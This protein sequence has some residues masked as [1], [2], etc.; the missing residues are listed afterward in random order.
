MF[1]SLQTVQAFYWLQAYYYKFW[2]AKPKSYES[3]NA[4]GVWY[5]AYS[6]WAL[7]ETISVITMVIVNVINVLLWCLTATNIQ[8]LIL[9]YLNFNSLVH[10]IDGLRFLWL[11]IVRTIGLWTDHYTS[12]YSYKKQYHTFKVSKE[13][14]IDFWDFMMEFAAITI[15]FG[16]YPD[17][18]S[19]KYIKPK[20]SGK[21]KYP[22]R[23]ADARKA[24]ATAVDMEEGEDEETLEI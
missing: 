23:P 7:A 18:K 22:A 14:F 24:A 12:Y 1:G 13:H 19:I 11:I 17:L 2:Y 10:Y 3:E 21:A 4:K 5:N 9:W 15:S 6:A 16:F 20:K 8:W